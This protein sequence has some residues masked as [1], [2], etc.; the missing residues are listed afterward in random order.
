VLLPAVDCEGVVAEGFGWFTGGLRK[1]VTGESW[2]DEATLV[3][4]PDVALWL[5]DV[6]ESSIAGVRAEALEGLKRACRLFDCLDLFDALPSAAGV[7]PSVG[8]FSPSC[9][10]GVKYDLKACMVARETL[11][12]K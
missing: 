6:C 9:V 7:N 10:T 5:P 2:Y 3:V 1:P 12:R 11:R 8:G 4:D